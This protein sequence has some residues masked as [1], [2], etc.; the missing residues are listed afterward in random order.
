MLRFKQCCSNGD[1]ELIPTGTLAMCVVLDLRFVLY[2]CAFKQTCNFFPDHL[3]CLSFCRSA[4]ASFNL[5]FNLQSSASINFIFLC[6]E[7]IRLLLLEDFSFCFKNALDVCLLL[8]LEEF[9]NFC[10]QKPLNLVSRKLQTSGSR[11]LFL[12]LQDC[13]SRLLASVSRSLWTSA[14]RRL[15]IS[16]S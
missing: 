3:C 4:V 1:C 15:W 9:I 5:H 12:L 6:Q 8:F 13:F 10:F 2:Y 14:S 11:R 16:V 7:N